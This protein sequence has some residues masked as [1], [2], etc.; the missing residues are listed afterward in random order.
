MQMIINGGYLMRHKL[1]NILIV[2]GNG[3]QHTMK[4]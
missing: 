1:D 4:K 2:I 3:R